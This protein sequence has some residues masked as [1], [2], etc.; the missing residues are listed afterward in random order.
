MLHATDADGHLARFGVPKQSHGAQERRGGGQIQG[1]GERE[2]SGL[3]RVGL[4]QDG[5]DLSFVR[6]RWCFF[7]ARVVEPLVL[8][9]ELCL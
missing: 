3:S 9:I 5:S 8:D 7:R 2:V 6:R 4:Y 1:E